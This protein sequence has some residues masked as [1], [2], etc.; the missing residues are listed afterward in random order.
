MGAIRLL[1][2]LLT[3]SSGLAEGLA[4]PQAPLVNLGASSSQGAFKPWGTPPSNDQSANLIFYRLATLLQHWPNTRYPSGQS[5]VPGT[6]PIGT[7][8]YHGR[9]GTQPPTTAEWLAFDPEHAVLFARGVDSRLFTYVTT[10]PLRV[11]YFDGSSAAKLSSGSADTQHFLAWGAPGNDTIFENERRII[12]DLCKWGKG[13]GIDGYVRMEQDFEI[14]HCDF[15]ENL[16]LVSSLHVLPTEGGGPGGP[17]GPRRDPFDSKKSQPFVLPSGTPSAPPEVPP[18][19][20]HRPPRFPSEPRPP[21]WKGA[22][23]SGEQRNFEVFQAGSWHNRAPGEVRVRLDAARLVTLYDPALK[24][25]IEIR[26]GKEKVL[27]RGKGMSYGDVA[28]WRGWV[29]DTLR[30]DK[31]ATSG[32]DWPA[33]TTVIMDRYGS[34]LEYLLYL[35]DSDRILQNST[36]VIQDVRSQL[37]LML[38]TDITTGNIP[39]LITPTASAFPARSSQI[40]RRETQNYTWV[41]PIAAHCA[42]FLVSHLPK[43]TMTRE[44]RTLYAAVSGTQAEI[45]RVLSLLWAEAY[46]PS[47]LIPA[48]VMARDWRQRVDGLMNWLDWPMWNRCNPECDLDS[49]CFIPTWPMGIGR[50]PG[51][52]EEDLSKVDWTPKCIPRGKHI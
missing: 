37:M 23:P 35:L 15:S 24:T 11:V 19:T 8:L 25:G 1:L 38:V 14:M 9:G 6:V 17:G 43:D 49:M 29:I 47:P 33:L 12:G 10:R 16:E 36:A 4:L 18:G 52:G 42:S 41:E 40:R 32:V 44:E 2:F 31:P 22:L 21:N 28:T 20:P 30:N 34:R 5:V 7:T 51:G 45:C 39:P 13:F 50:M 46:D 3:G 26:E 48:E 27:H